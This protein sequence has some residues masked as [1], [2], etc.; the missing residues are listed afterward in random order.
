MGTV[1]PYPVYL[2]VPRDYDAINRTIDSSNIWLFGRGSRPQQKLK[3]FRRPRH[4]L[5]RFNGIRANSV[6]D[7][8][9]LYKTTFNIISSHASVPYTLRVSESKS[10][11]LIEL[12]AS[13][14]ETTRGQSLLPLISFSCVPLP[15]RGNLPIR[16]SRQQ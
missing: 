5:R 9:N 10:L 1:T 4:I 12:L 2:R 8:L 7:L 3:L 11:R 16:L 13:S 15:L 14:C 6:R